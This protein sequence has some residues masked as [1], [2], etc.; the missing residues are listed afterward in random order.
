MSGSLKRYDGNFNET[1]MIRS[2][3][4]QLPVVIATYRSSHLLAYFLQLLLLRPHF[5]HFSLRLHNFRNVQLDALIHHSQIQ[6]V[7]LHK[8]FE[9]GDMILKF[10]LSTNLHLIGVQYLDNVLC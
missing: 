6:F 1:R 8:L 3:G 4:Y 2:R 9:I 5:E 7:L 10:G